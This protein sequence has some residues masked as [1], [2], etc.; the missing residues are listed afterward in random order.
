MGQG[1]YLM[2]GLRQ[3]TQTRTL[4]A[5]LKARRREAGTSIPRHRQAKILKMQR[6][7]MGNRTLREQIKRAAS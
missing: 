6:Q 1:D 4:M 7:S 2:G 5:G 3:I